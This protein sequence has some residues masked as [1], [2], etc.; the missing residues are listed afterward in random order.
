MKR[1]LFISLF[2]LPSLVVSAE[3]YKWVDENGN[4]HFGDRP[5][6][7]DAEKVKV[8]SA[9]DIDPALLERLKKQQKMLDIYDEERQEHKAEQAAI[10]EEKKKRAANCTRAQKELEGMR[11]ASFLYQNT[12]DPKNPEILSDKQ[13]ADET[14]KAE[15]RVKEWCK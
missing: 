8:H 1:I 13:R 15:E 10:E 11:N 9:P 12:D 14:V 6:T 2:V 5:D 4:T 3:I 7:E